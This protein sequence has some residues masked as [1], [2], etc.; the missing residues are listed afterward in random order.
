VNP[1][2]LVEHYE[3]IRGQVLGQAGGPRWGQTLLLDQGVAAW[4]RA[5]GQFVAPALPVP[6]ASPAVLS[7]LAS[8]V[9]DDLVRLMGEA[10]LAAAE[11]S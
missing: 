8:G 11:A 10:V 2:G 5:V 6:A 9:H 1:A 4:M 3:K 7:P